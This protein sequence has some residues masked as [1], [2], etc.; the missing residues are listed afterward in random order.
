MVIVGRAVRERRTTGVCLAE[1]RNK[2]DLPKIL[3]PWPLHELLHVAFIGHYGG[4]RHGVVRLC[5]RN[6]MLRHLFIGSA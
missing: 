6:D 1:I 5:A 4:E 2:A 3:A